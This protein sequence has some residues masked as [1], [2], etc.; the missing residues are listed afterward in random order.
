MK[1]SQS[2]FPHEYRHNL[3]V[4]SLRLNLP[5]PEAR[6]RALPDVLLTAQALLKM[7][8]IGKITAFADLQKRAGLRQAAL[9]S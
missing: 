8:E 3:D 6:H 4:L 1:L 2:I 7:M 5:K 9:R